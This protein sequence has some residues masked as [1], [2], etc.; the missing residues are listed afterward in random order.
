MVKHCKKGQNHRLTSD[1]GVSFRNWLCWRMV[2]SWIMALS[3]TCGPAIRPWPTQTSLCPASTQ[4]PSLKQMY[5]LR[6][7]TAFRAGFYMVVND[8][9]LWCLLVVSQCASHLLGKMSFRISE[10]FIICLNCYSFWFSL[11]QTQINWLRRYDW[12]W[13]MRR[14]KEGMFFFWISS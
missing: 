2:S 11:Y 8:E 12:A 9:W 3:L 1:Y 6:W 4:T 10:I 7:E 14:Q 5:L 13:N